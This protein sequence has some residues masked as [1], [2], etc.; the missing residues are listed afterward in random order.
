M[1]NKLW[2]FVAVVML[3][4]VLIA[5]LLTTMQKGSERWQKTSVN[6]LVQKIQGDLRQMYWQWQDEGRPHSILYKPQNVERAH[7]VP[8]SLKGR[9]V[10]ARNVNGCM[11]FMQWFIDQEHI[12]GQLKAVF[13]D[14]TQRLSEQKSQKVMPSKSIQELSKNIEQN[15]FI[16]Q[17][18]LFDF[19]Y[20]YNADSGEVSTTKLE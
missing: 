15:Q 10:I 17:Y 11:Q 5:W 8:M 12:N 6:A 13:I 2:H 4:A 19:Q 18:E 7:L 20:E 16:C 9:P 14:T 3:V 1:A